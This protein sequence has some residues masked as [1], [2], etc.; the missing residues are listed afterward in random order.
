MS[1]NENKKTKVK[2]VLMSINESKNCINEYK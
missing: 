1:M 2:I